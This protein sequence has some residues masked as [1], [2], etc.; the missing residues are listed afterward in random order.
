[1]GSSM[2]GYRGN[3]GRGFYTMNLHSLVYTAS[4]GAN[5][6][7][8]TLLIMTWTP[9]QSLFQQKL[10]RQEVISEFDGRIQ[11]AEKQILKLDH[12]V[13][14]TTGFLQNTKEALQ[15]LQAAQKQSLGVVQSVQDVEEQL[16]WLTIVQVMD[17]ERISSE[18]ITEMLGALL[19]QLP[20]VASNPFYNQVKVQI[21]LTGD[22]TQEEI[23]TKIKKDLEEM[24]LV[25]QL[26]HYINIGKGGSNQQ[27]SSAYDVLQ[28]WDGVQ[29]ML[30]SSHNFLF[31]DGETKLCSNALL[32]I[33]YV[34]NKLAMD[35]ST[36]QWQA[37]HFSEQDFATLVSKPGVNQLLEYAKTSTTKYPNT[38]Q[39]F[40]GWMEEESKK[41]FKIISYRYD[42][43]TAAPGSDRHSNLCHD[44]LSYFQNFLHS[45]QDGAKCSENDVVP[46]AG[47]DTLEWVSQNLKLEPLQ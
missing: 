4:I 39:L 34:T 5:F 20:A 7:L 30:K 8:I 32:A 35:Q 47:D 14:A 29:Q 45:V 26:Q 3:N 42:L 21:I 22:S 36:Q 9:S 24:N 46:C 13:R 41:S 23:S 19:G 2:P 43:T 11:Q 6:I 38:K 18:A 12:S 10:Q 44:E 17:I 28:N 31:L 1:M 33:Q 37:I 40:L 16:R 15:T 27:F 25:K